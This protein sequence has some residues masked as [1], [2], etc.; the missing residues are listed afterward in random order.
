M[1]SEIEIYKIENGYI[2]EYE[3][4]SSEGVTEEYKVYFEEKSSVMMYVD[5][6]LEG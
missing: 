2:V 5:S 6:L 4:M 3:K 1:V